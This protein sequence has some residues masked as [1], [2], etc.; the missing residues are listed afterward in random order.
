MRTQLAGTSVAANLTGF[1]SN[2]TGATW[3]LSATNAGD[4]LAH[5]VT[6]KG[7]AATDHSA[8]T[9]ILTGTDANGARLTETVNLPNGTATVTSTNYFLTLTTVV[10]SATIGADTMDIGWALASCTNTY[11]PKTAG[12]DLGQF[13]IGIGCRVVTGSPTYSIQH[14]YDHIA[15][16]EHAT[17][18]GK[19]VSFDGVITSPVAG[20]RL[21]F[22][23]AGGV[24]ANVIQFGV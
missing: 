17:I 11:F 1:L 2:A 15:W 3:T 12:A 8:K 7:D 5:K 22:A 18:T 14:T 9:A 10:P 20:I 24:A 6:I 19:L 4:S 23:A 21:Q 13:N 16:F